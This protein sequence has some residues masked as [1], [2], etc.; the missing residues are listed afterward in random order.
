VFFKALSDGGTGMAQSV[1]R[2]KR[3]GKPAPQS[4][5]RRRQQQRKLQRE[6][7]GRIGRVVQETLEQALVDEVTVLLGRPKHARRGEAPQRR[8]GATCAQCQHDWAPRF[9]RA[10]SYRRTLSTTVATVRLRVPRESCG[11]GGQVPL[12]FATFGRYARSWGDLQ[13][14]VRQLAGLCLSLTDIQEVVAGESGAWLAASTLNHWVHEAAALAAVL[15]GEP[16]ARVPSVVLLDGLW[17][18]LMVETGARYHDRRGRDRP[19]VR[20]VT[21]PLLVAYG[22]D[23]GTGER[24]LLDWE[25][26]AGEDTASWQGLLERLEHRGL[27]ADAGL[28]LFVSDGSSGLEAAFGLV[29]F[30]PGVL[31]QRCIF[32]VLR[33]GRQ[34]VRGAPGMTRA[35]KRARR[36]DVLQAATAIWQPRDPTA[37]R[38][39]YTAFRDAW[40][41][42]EPAA[43]AAL[44]RV[45][46][47]TLAY[48]DARARGRELGEVWTVEYLRTTSALERVNRAL[49]QKARQVGTFQAARGLTAAVV[50][51]LVH[52]GLTRPTRP[53]ALWTEV[54]EAGLLAS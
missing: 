47:A 45:F 25:Q 8:A 7:A 26:G 53:Q 17:V 11:C 35:E 4:A 23:P 30:G 49:R 40:R 44:E 3:R 18:K 39:A 15:R 27:R 21:V 29:N 16:F 1:A 10:G 20:R 22:V 6:L 41:E 9:S 51:V 32:H 5:E 34:E 48:L 31:H 13:E 54:L 38:R 42:R 33:T 36:R 50:L 52:R 43:V 14:R 19:R 37:V 2:R 24:W 12:E 28:T 46:D